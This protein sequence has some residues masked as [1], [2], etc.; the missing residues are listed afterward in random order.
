MN[1]THRDILT[2]IAPPTQLLINN[3]WVEPVEKEHI[4]IV[5]PTTEEVLCHVASGTSKDVDLAVKAARSAFATWSR[6]D[7]LKR[8]QL[9]FKLA[10]LM[11]RDQHI[12]G[13]LDSLTTGKPVDVATGYDVAQSISVFRYYAGWC[14]KLPLGDV[15]P[16]ESEFD[17]VVKKEP[18]GVIGCIVPWNFP[19]MLASWKLGPALCTGCTIIIKPA[20]Q[21]PLS[22]LWLGKLAVE[23]GFPPGVLNIV[24]GY[25]YSAGQAM[26]SHMDIDKISFTGSTETGRRVMIS[27]AESNLKKVSLELGGKSANV[28]FEDC[29]FD[30]AVDGACQAL[31]LNTGENCCAGSRLYVQE[32]IYD[33]FVKALKSKVD[34][35]YV[36]HPFSSATAQALKDGRVVNGPL[37]DKRQFEKVLSYIDIGKKEGATL[38]TGGQRLGTQGY[39][40]EPTV[41]SDVLNGMRISKEEIFGPVLVVHKFKTFDEVIGYVNDCDY[42]LASAVWSNNIRTVHDFCAQVKSG[43]VWTNTYN[44]VKYNVPFGGVRMT[45]FGRDL[46]KEALYEYMSVKSLIHKI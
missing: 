13:Q 7:P 19:L 23:A 39:F 14:D 11:E 6:Y 17:V 31:F 38:L 18:L 32:S 37:I 42:G 34:N 3:A 27:S 33:D 44:I 24:T 20:E 40:V 4:A 8:S 22:V 43:I 28:V 10:D 41:F 15:V 25:G 36:G 45:G 2:S 30:A 21:T 35:I 1:E 16:S 9:M 46:G 12:L 5:D 26:V 29:D